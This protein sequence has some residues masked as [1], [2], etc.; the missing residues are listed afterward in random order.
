MKA[1]ALEG[2]ALRALTRFA[3]SQLASRLGMR[4]PAQR[5]LY[6]GARAGA[7]AI[8]AGAAAAKH[9]MAGE[10][11]RLAPSK[12]SGIFD[13]RPTE[14]QALMRAT[15]RRFA[16][17]VL[18]SAA[19]AADDAASPPDEVLARGHAL[20]LAGLAIP[21]ALGGAATECTAVTGAL[22]AEELARGDMGLATAVL[23]P[24][25]VVHA[26]VRWG[27]ADQQARYL[28]R[29]L[30][31]RFVSA[32]LALLEPRPQFDP[33]HPQVGAVRSRDG[34]WEIWGEKSLVPLAATAELFVVVAD[35]R[36]MGARLFIVERDA[37][38]LTIDLHP[39]MG[40]RGA[41]LGRLRFDGVRVAE[42]ALVGGE[43]AASEFDLG[44]LVDR[45]RIA[46]GAMAV[47]VAQ[48]VLDYVVPYTS[49][50]QAFGE[51]ISNRQAVAFLVADIA[52]E[53]EGMRL[54]VHRAAGRADR[55]A[56]VGRHAALAR[57]QCASKGMKIGSDGVQLLG[58]HGFVKE[59]PVER[60]Y[61][62]L[63]AAGVF[64][65]ALLA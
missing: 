25:A 11:H 52:I 48:A 39:A 43:P 14:E 46:W 9:A 54:L 2:I 51:P 42:D 10:A 22:I 64:E 6:L 57:L 27:T 47:G 13:V 61:R 29:F 12:S 65:G 5:A 19:R 1:Q 30:G 44:D 38:G 7:R 21:E 24:L 59:H 4:R 3:G 49:E 55:N 53:L 20:G 41:G 35:V 23:A 32:A 28:P 60:W 8:T 33:M 15:M 26:L 58:G 62:D 16:D 34:G 50:R 63:R 36:G 45:A 31:E 37:A 17:E 18:R 56:E 40:V